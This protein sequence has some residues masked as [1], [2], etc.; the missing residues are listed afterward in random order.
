MEGGEKGQDGRLRL[1]DFM[2]YKT[3]QLPLHA[4]SRGTLCPIEFEDLPFKPKRTYFL[5]DTG[6]L[7]GG[8]A[9][10]REQELFVCLNGSF[11]ATVHDGKL[12]RRFHMKKRGQALYTNRLVWHEFDNFSADAIMMALSS[13]RY[14]GKKGYIM[15]FEEFVCKAKSS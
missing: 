11:R 5:F 1:V 6:A 12:W 4:D 7:R 15:D 3:F 8:H 10:M 9:H 13:T 14:N 2:R